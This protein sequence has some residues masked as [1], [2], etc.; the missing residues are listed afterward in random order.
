MMTQTLKG[1][2]T[3]LFEVQIGYVKKPIMRTM[4]FVSIK[5]NKE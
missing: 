5:L 4:E 2:M 3:G 1:L